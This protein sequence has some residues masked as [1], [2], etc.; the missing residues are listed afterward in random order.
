LWRAVLQQA[1]ADAPV[2]AAVWIL[3]VCAIALLAAA[4][5]Y[6]D[7][8]ARGGLRQ[9]VLE[10]PPADRATTVRTRAPLSAAD[11][12]D[13]TIRPELEL[14][15][16][17]P[18]GD[19]ARVLRSGVFLGADGTG[20]TGETE[21]GRAGIPEGGITRLAAFEGLER[22][23]TLTA[24]RWPEAG[25][26]P[27]EVAMSTGAVAALGAEVGATLALQAER[28][29][30]ALTVVVAG[31]WTPASD[32]A[33]WLGAPL[34][35][36][37]VAA[38]S[39]V[40]EYGPLVVAFDDLMS[41]GPPGTATL[42]WR[43]LPDLDGLR[44]DDLDATIAD[45]RAFPARLRAALPRDQ[46]AE[47]TTELPEVLTAMSRSIVVSRSGVLLLSLQFA[48]LAAYAVILV[49]G[50]I[51][52]RRRAQ[53]ALLRSRGAT[54]VHLVAMAVAEGVLLAA[55]AALVAPLVAVLVV[56]LLGSVEPLSASGIVADVPIGRTTVVVTA[57]AAAASVVALSLPTVTSVASLAG[58]RAALARQ[59]GRTLPQRLGIDLAL[60]ILAGVALWQLRLY[61]AP[62]VRNARGELGIDP[63][64]VA[65]P[66][67]GLVAGAVLAIRLVPRLGEVA[68]G[69]LVRRAGA[70]APLGGRQL[71]RRPLSYSR[72]ALLLMLAV[73]LGTFALAQS[74]TWSRSQE[75][76]AA[77]Q[78]ATDLRLVVS[79]F[80]DVP[81][82]AQGAAY[83]TIPGI[84]RAEPV[85]RRRIDVRRAVRGGDLLAIDAAAAG[86]LVELPPDAVAA[87]APA[88]LAELAAGRP[89]IGGVPLP[90]QPL[91]LALTIDARLE[92]ERELS[93]GVD[94]EPEFAGITFSAAVDDA[95]GRLVRLAGGSARLVGDGQ[96]IEASIRAPNDPPFE[97]AWPLRLVA[98]ELQVNPRF[99]AAIGT[100]DLVSV[101]ASGEPTGDAWFPVALDPGA[102][103]WG[104]ERAEQSGT[105]R[106]GTPTDRPGRLL[107]RAGPGGNG[108]I[109]AIFSGPPTI[110]RL[111]APDPL[112]ALPAIV[113]PVI[114]ERTGLAVGDT[115]TALSLGQALPI[116]VIGSVG[117]FPPLDPEAPFA[118]VDRQSFER[119]SF[120]RDAI[121][122]R[123]DE[124]WFRAAAG[125]DAD[126]LE[127]LRGEPTTAEDV[128]GRIEL[129]AELSSDPIGLGVIGA[130]GLGTAAALVFAA[131]GFLVSAA[132][133]ATE[134]FGEFALLRALGL[135]GR[136]LS[137]WLTLENAFLLAVGLVAG[138]A[139]GLVLA[140]VVLP[141]STLTDTGAPTVPP[142]AVVIPW[143]DYA[144]IW[145]LAGLLLVLSVVVVTRTIRAVRI[146]SVLRARDG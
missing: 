136:D 35:L 140:W 27:V 121:T 44:A 96:R 132:S 1:R 131:I 60:L 98:I 92:A 9:A 65:A 126:L 66:A 93:G 94:L 99:A 38:G 63:L 76:Q 88:L 22:H 77:Y 29:S 16:R 89:E 119:V 53:V 135:S 87:G 61:G 122:L 109:F 133:S 106:V 17:Y 41:H 32:D 111:S 59:G 101:E 107:L 26:D 143:Q 45:L 62:L 78:A 114:L 100:I 10:A 70:V 134:R 47:A 36:D 49:A 7:A 141:V 50:V 120:D 95:D 73:S 3:L 102:T 13:G 58:V 91:R 6:G 33:Y 72:S 118:V 83:R 90:G 139:V 128:I 40:T 124:W 104:W 54:S 112:D 108:P 75:D 79:G 123:P 5:H 81:T 4:A 20:D 31:T 74:A 85:L 52:E 42:E 68:E 37:G 138:S 39:R 18:G 145:L 144:P 8:I 142:A 137:T 69:L 34:D 67:I 46:Q 56:R 129:A 19:V 43:A 146:S 71:A 117:L 51:V 30:T 48:V 97:P 113:N 80:P 12:L 127:R 55:T 64:L 14:A 24:G 2:I 86:G 105:I 23:A 130:L 125:A 21:P 115:V 11:S 84:E 103:G 82:W 110:F 15:L 28:G 57:L 25:H 116:R